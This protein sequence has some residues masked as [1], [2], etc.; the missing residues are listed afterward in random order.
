[1]QPVFLSLRASIVAACS[2]ARRWCVLLFVAATLPACYDADTAYPSAPNDQGSFSVAVVEDSLTVRVGES[3]STSVVL[4]RTGRFADSIALSVVSRADG[5]NLSIAGTASSDSATLTLFATATLAPGPYVV[6]VQARARGVGL[7]EHLVVLTVLDSA[8]LEPVADRLF[9]GD[10]PC[11]LTTR[12]AAYCWGVNRAGEVGNGSI[13]AAGVPVPTLVRGDHKFSTLAVSKTGGVTCGVRRD[14]VALCWGAN[15]VGQLGDGT[16]TARSVPTAVATD[17]RFRGVAVGTSHACAVTFDGD[18]A[19]WGNSPNGAFGDG[20]AGPRRLPHIM[21]SPFR[22]SQITAGE[23]FTCALRDNGTA[24]CWGQGRQGQLGDG[25]AESSLRPVAVAGEITFKQIV[26]AQFSV[27]GLTFDGLVYCW[28]NNEFGTIGDGTTG[29]EG[30]VSRHRTPTR[31]VSVPG[32]TSITAG[33]ETVCGVTSDRTAYCWGY[34]GEGEVGDG[35]FESRAIP[36]RVAQSL[37]LR[38][39]VAGTTTTCALT[40]SR[41]V[42]CWGDNLHGALGDNDTVEAPRSSPVFVHWPPR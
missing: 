26:A 28:G 21:P 40:V 11:L 22:F 18:I 24:Y 16:T 31:V 12:G 15:L 7:R 32:L 29:L 1:M 27:C 14:G 5:L 41:A 19:C 30:G 42:A 13:N 17:L 3:V 35:T 25:R 10:H 8:A 4:Q 33:Y 9:V 34:N 23:D 38:S 20:T 37:D 39:V 36:T 6:V 2:H